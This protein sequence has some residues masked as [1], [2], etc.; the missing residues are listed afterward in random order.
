MNISE[1]MNFFLS[2]FTFLTQVCS[3][4]MEATTAV[5]SNFE[6]EEMTARVIILIESFNWKESF[7]VYSPF[8]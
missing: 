8:P 1:V 4:Q 2:F 6:G 3:F 7:A 5:F